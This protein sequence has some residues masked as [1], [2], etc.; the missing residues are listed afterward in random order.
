MKN[1]SE[2]TKRII[3]LNGP[4]GAGKDTAA[5]II[6]EKLHGM[7]Y[8]YKMALPLKESCHKLLGLQGTL[9]ELEPLKSTM[10]KFLVQD[11]YQHW[12]IMKLVNDHGEMTLRQFYIHMSENV[13]K[14]MFGE[15]YF[16][17]LAV[18]N[19]RQCHHTIATVSDSGFADEAAPVIDY[20]GKDRI[21]LVK[22][23][24]PGTNFG[25]DSRSYVNLDVGT[26]LEI[27]NDQNV[28]EFSNRLWR[29][30]KKYFLNKVIE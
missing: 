1:K 5:H 21:C 23:F 10:I 24:R 17:R 28:E 12:P 29:K 20:F 26:V 14:P 15:D 16:G 9:E 2:Q 13:I 3:L 19:L 30:L 6:N 11:S 7:S 22:L 25:G 18:E 4:P 8:Q 27:Q